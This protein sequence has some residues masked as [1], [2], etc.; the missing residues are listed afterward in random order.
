MRRWCRDCDPYP[1]DAWHFS[2]RISNYIDS[3]FDALFHP[4]KNFGALKAL[5]N[6]CSPFFLQLCIFLHL[7]KEEIITPDLERQIYSRTLVIFREAREQGMVMRVFTCFGR[8]TKFFSLER[9]NKKI[10]FDELPSISLEGDDVPF[11]DKYIF[12][13]A[14]RKMNFPTPDGR[15]CKTVE[16]ALDAANTLG[17]PLVV[18][19]R[20]GSL[21]KHT[22]CGIAD[23]DDLR[24]AVKSV[25]MITREYIVERYI[26]GHVFRVTV[27]G[28]IVGGCCLR[29]APHVVG[30]GVRT[31]SELV[32]KKN[33]DPRRGPLVQKNT[34]LHHIVVTPGSREKLLAQSIALDGVP[35]QGEKIFLHSK[36]I[37][38]AG[39]DIHD[40]TDEIHPEN[41]K[42]FEDVA[43]IWD[44]PLVGFDAIFQDVSVSWRDQE[45]GIIEANSKPYI[46]MHHVPV[47][48]Q[49]RNIA[50][51][52]IDYIVEKNI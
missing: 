39:A 15:T 22:T 38:G 2:D 4:L 24:Q 31:V 1:C 32:Q 13:C 27:V 10:I 9:D 8:G 40:R 46:D 16:Q 44:A 41:K 42:L 17:Y 29:E 25:K 20:R 48:G 43:K 50:K 23:E 12:K 7:F 11:S 52:L 36:V 51:L 33:T 34:T 5:E 6:R 47:T 37:L 18:K 26:P 3:V 45:C 21:S 28:G 19:P 30:D 14:L 49:P 35:G